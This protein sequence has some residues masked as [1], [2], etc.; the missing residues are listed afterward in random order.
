MITGKMIRQD[1]TGLLMLLT[2][3]RSFLIILPIIIL[4]FLFLFSGPA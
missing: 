1:Q 3:I 2:P 4:P